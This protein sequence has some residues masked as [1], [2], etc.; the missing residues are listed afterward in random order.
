VKRE[1]IWQQQGTQPVLI[2]SPDRFNAMTRVPIVL[3]VTSRGSFA[4]CFADGAGTRT[5]GVVRCDQT[6]PIDLVA[7]KARLLENVPAHVMDEVLA[8]LAP[9]FCE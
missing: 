3:P 2:F 4:R 5:T 8:R 6:R 9:M 7:R 1:K